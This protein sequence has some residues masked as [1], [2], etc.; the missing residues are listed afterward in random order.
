MTR[1][2]PQV[3]T[4]SLFNRVAD[5]LGFGNGDGD[6]SEARLDEWLENTLK[7]EFKVNRIERDEDGDIPIPWGSAVVFLR[8]FEGD[9]PH[10][11]VFAPLLADFAMRAEVYEAVNAINRKIP[12]A[13]A[14]VD[15]DICQITLSA[16]L[17][18]IDDISTD[19]LMAT[20]ELVG[21]H[22]DHYDTLLQKR[23]GGEIMFDDDEDELDV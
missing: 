5:R 16:Q 15:P 17:F 10:I 2:G 1:F 18:L 4:M 12:V 9:P 20:I 11:E 3:R 23:F 14:I 7:R 8:T 13:K 6:G 19:Q 21:E 22:A